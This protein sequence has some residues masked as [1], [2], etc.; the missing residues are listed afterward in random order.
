M[1][2]SVQYF[3][4]QYISNPLRQEPRNVGIVARCGAV[5]GC[6]FIGEGHGAK[7][8][9]RKLRSFRFPDV[10]KQWVA[11]WR[12]S[13]DRETD[14]EALAEDNAPHYRLVRGGSVVDI[15][16]DPIE[17]V[18]AYLFRQLVKDEVV[19][20]GSDQVS[21]RVSTTHSF[22][23]E[24]TSAFEGRGLLYSPVL[25]RGLFGTH[26]IVR[27]RKL[28]GTS[29]AVYRPQFSQENGDLYLMESFDFRGASASLEGRAGLAA[30]MY[31]DIGKTRNVVSIS[32]I[33]GLR[34]RNEKRDVMNSVWMLDAESRI[35]DWA[36]PIDRDRFLVERE[37]IARS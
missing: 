36:D 6:R 9:G 17:K 24:L 34:E 27:N 10:Y 7:I 31:R 15:G 35:V 20:P 18:V 32:L 28:S 23:K 5:R 25:Q 11:Y 30:Y 33:K 37:E 1:A 3:I 14:I 4:A 26:P 12:E 13:L 16:A 19:Q 22:T 21:E 2:E 8:D 29:K